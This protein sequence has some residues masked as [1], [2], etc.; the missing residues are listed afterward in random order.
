MILEVV[1]DFVT[2]GMFTFGIEVV[3]R[4]LGDAWDEEKDEEAAKEDYHDIRD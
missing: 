3:G 1:R 2:A 4:A